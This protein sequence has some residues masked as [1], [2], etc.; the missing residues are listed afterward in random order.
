MA[1]NIPT[2]KQSTKRTITMKSEFLANSIL[3][4]QRQIKAIQNN[5][6]NH[7]GIVPASWYDELQVLE[8]KLEKATKN[9]Q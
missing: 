4:A 5:I 7:Y 2:L 1:H 3:D 8:T 6:R 9:D